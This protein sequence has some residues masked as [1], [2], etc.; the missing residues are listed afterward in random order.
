[1]TS[2]HVVADVRLWRH[3]DLIAGIASNLTVATD[4]RDFTAALPGAL[5]RTGSTT[6]RLSPGLIAG[7]QL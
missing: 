3:V 6:V 1:V 4:G 2:L 5:W 7:L